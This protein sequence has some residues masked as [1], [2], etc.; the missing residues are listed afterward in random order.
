MRTSLANALT[1]LNLILGMLAV[2]LAIQGDFQIAAL[3]VIAGMVCDG[4]DGWLARALHIQSDFGKELDSLA[5]I[6]AFGVAPAV[7]MYVA[8]L[9]NAGIAGV[10]IAVLF[11]VAGA[12]RLARFNVQPGRTN[13]FVGLPITA[14]GGILATFALYHGL[15]PTLW[16]P[17][18]T[19][20]LSYLMV[21]K[22]RY[23]NFK[24][25]GLPRKAYIAIPVLAAVAAAVMIT[26]RDVMARFIFLILAVYGGYGIWYDV[27]SIWRKKLRKGESEG[28]RS[29]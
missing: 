9:R 5:D 20:A 18:L 1:I 8:V 22:T 3:F 12:L 2:M 27:R 25:L 19:V 16:L 13:Y 7:I 6:V 10:V 21:S 26:H 11:P 14:A 4:L 24:K 15:I 29:T 28:Y 17:V 23:P